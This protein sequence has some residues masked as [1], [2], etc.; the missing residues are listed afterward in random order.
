MSTQL[1]TWVIEVWHIVDFVVDKQPQI[2]RL[3]VICNLF[4]LHKQ[5]RLH[6]FTY[7]KVLHLFLR[8][9]WVP[10]LVECL[11]TFFTGVLLYDVWTTRMTLIK[12]WQIIH[13]A[14]DDNPEV[15]R[16]VMELELWLLNFP[17]GISSWLGGSCRGDGIFSFGRHCQIFNYKRGIVWSIMF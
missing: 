14:I 2:S 6:I 16:F 8:W 3:I 11:A 5:F 10:H 1:V 9:I 4:Q 15:V 13:L 12:L 17:K 7:Y